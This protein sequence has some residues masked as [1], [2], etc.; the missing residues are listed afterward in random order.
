MGMV[1]TLAVITAALSGAGLAWSLLSYSGTAPINIFTC[2]WVL[3]VPQLALLVIL[4]LSLLVSRAG[5]APVFKGFYPLLAALFRRLIMS[6]KKAGET[7][8]TGGQ[9][10]SLQAMAGFVGRQASLYGPVFF[11]PIFLLA[12][13]FTV[14]FNLGIL[15]ATLLKL[16]ITDLAFGWQSTLHPTPET[17]YHLIDAFSMP[18]S[19]MPAAHPTLAQI[20]GSQMILKDGMVHLSTLD[21]VFWWPFLCHAL[22]WYGNG[23]PAA[24]GSAAHGGHQQQ[25]KTSAGIYRRLESRSPEAFQH[26]PAV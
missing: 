23:N 22:V 12:Q 14:F 11:W 10:L 25:G 1:R 5:V 15:C 4:G 16:A 26:H 18:W 20:Q 6:V 13:I 2:V 21:I 19:F 8:L 3:L 7:S 9:R 24:H 17:V